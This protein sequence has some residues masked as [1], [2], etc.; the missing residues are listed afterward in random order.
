MRLGEHRSPQLFSR[1]D[2]E[3][4]VDGAQVI[5]D[6]FRAQVQPGCGL[7]RGGAFRQSERDLQLLWRQLLAGA[8]T[9]DTAGFSAGLQLRH[10]PL[11]PWRRAKLIERLECRS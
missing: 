11:R 6:S 10:R 1:P 2:L 7:A 4:V 8:V 9:A 5:L 3:L